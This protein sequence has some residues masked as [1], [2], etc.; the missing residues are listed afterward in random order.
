MSC[1]GLHIVARRHIQ[2]H[3]DVGLEAVSSQAIM[4]HLFHLSHD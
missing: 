1:S 4:I 2:I 3:K